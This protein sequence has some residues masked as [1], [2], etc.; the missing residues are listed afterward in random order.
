MV[1]ELT[2]GPLPGAVPVIVMFGPAPTARLARVQASTPATGAPQVH[3][4][5]EPLT[6]V[7]FPG[8]LSATE[9][10]DAGGRPG[11]AGTGAP[12]V[13]PAREPLT[14]VRFPGRLSATETL[15]AASGPALFTMSV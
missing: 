14:L 7:W 4:V 13:H 3:P 10:L 6:L 9:T 1:A 5:P 12:Q 8:R 15:D 2:S 11:A